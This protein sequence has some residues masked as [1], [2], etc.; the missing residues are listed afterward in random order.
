LIIQKQPRKKC[1]PKVV[2]KN[3][4]FDSKIKFTGPEISNTKQMGLL[5]GYDYEKYRIR[6]WKDKTTGEIR[7]QI[8]IQIKYSG[9]WRFYRTASF[10]A[11][12]QQSLVEI[13]HKVVSCY[14]YGC[15]LKETVGVA[16]DAD[17]LF[18]HKRR[19]LH[20][21]IDSK[22]GHENFINI[23]YNYT[24]GYLMAISNRM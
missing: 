7:H 9:G 17:F 2:F 11:G 22:S 6:G 5:S 24:S 15:T 19:D 20:I 1:L 3:S 8:Y 16:V 21:R 12:N 13:D 10:D 23:P 4:N 14:K 18:K